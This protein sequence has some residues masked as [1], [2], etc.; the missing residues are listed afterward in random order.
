MRL[1][2]FWSSNSIFPWRE[3]F[4]LF[5]GGN[6]NF[7]CEC[8][9]FVQVDFFFNAYDTFYMLLA[10]FIIVRRHG[11]IIFSSDQIQI[12]WRIVLC[13][14]LIWLK[15]FFKAIKF[16]F[17]DVI[18]VRYDHWIWSLSMIKFKKL[19][20]VWSNSN[21][22]WSNCNHWIIMIK[23]KKFCWGNYCTDCVYYIWSYDR[24]KYVDVQGY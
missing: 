17:V 6:H 23:F 2:K 3:D 21:W 19:C 5:V 11:E 8:Q 22:V 9:N 1:L 13:D 20:W 18:I 14:H 10:L 15:L 12:C 24:M 7:G 4:G 16:K